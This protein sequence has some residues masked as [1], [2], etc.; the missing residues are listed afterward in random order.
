MQKVFPEKS[1]IENL[2]KFLTGNPDVSGRK[3]NE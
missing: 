1:A 3:I 2:T